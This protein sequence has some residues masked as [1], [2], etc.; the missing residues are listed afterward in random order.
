MKKITGL[1]WILFCLAGFI[2]AEIPSDFAAEM[3]KV[4]NHFTKIE[5]FSGTILV[6]Q[7]GKVLYAKAFGEANKDFRVPNTLQTRFELASISKLF[8][9]IAVLQLVEKGKIGL[10]DPVLK[11][12]P[13]FPFGDE[14]TIRHLLTHTSGLPDWT[15]HRRFRSIWNQVKTIDQMIPLIYDQK[16]KHETPGEKFIYNS[17]GFILMG[18]ILEMEYGKNFAAVIRENILVP[19]GMTETSIANPED[20]VE[21]RATGYV[22]SSTGRFSTNVYWL[23]PFVASAGIQSTV[24]DMLKLDQALYGDTLISRELQEKM[25]RPFIQENWGTLWRLGEAYGNKIAWHGGETAGVSAM[26]RR[27]LKDKLTLVIL[28]NYHRA[29]RPLTWV[30]EP[31]LFGEA[32]ELPKPT[33]GEFL[34]QEMKEK[35]TEKTAPHFEALIKE[36]G[37]VVR[38]QS[39][40]NEFGYELLEEGWMDM[41]LEIFKLNCRLF[42]DKPNTFDSLA[43]AYLKKGNLESALKYYEKA[44]ELNPKFSPSLMGLKKVKKLMEK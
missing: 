7:E 31:L 30:V 41:A 16:L 1:V 2:S 38:S 44:L 32:Y 24:G 9:G 40:L 25:V 36:A 19:L 28:S 43:E 21:N 27:Y 14:I 8:T 6:A 11:H 33:L 10:D 39:D 37:Y 29:G 5:H 22:K 18:K 17:S 4:M 13:D 3:D 34:F 26:F 35:G 23:L 42:P 15:S 12:L 20:V